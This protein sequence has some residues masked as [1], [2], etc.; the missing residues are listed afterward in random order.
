M[1]YKHFSLLV[2]VAALQGSTTATERHVLY[3]RE[4]LKVVGSK[5]FPMDLSCEIFL[6]ETQIP[7]F[8]IQ[9]KLGRIETKTVN[10]NQE[11][12]VS[13]L[14]KIGDKES[15]VLYLFSE[16]QDGKVVGMFDLNLDGEWDVKKT[17]TRDQKN[18]IRI[19]AQWH[20]VDSIDGLTLQ[21]PTAVKGAS[22]YEFRGKWVPLSIRGN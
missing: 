14:R 4:P 22:N 6:G 3:E 12:S 20:E 11:S 17:P 8:S 5:T 1:W 18:F 7:S 15:Y 9:G 10:I 16:D 19:G 21:T 13:V 2:A